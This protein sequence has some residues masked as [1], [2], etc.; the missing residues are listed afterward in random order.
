MKKRLLTLDDLY[1]FYSTKK[2]SM[3]FSS[4]KSGY[5]LAVQIKGTFEIVNNDNSEG[6]LYGKCRAF[7]DLGNKNK[8]YIDTEILKEKMM[9]LKDRP[10][11]AHISET[12]E[13]DE[14]GN[15]IKDFNGHTM[16]WDD[17]LQKFIYIEH[18]V[19]HF[20]NPEK[21]EL[22]YDETYDRHFV[23]GDIV[24]YEE[25]SDACDI[26]RRRETVD[27]SV[28]LCIRDLTYNCKTGEMHLNDFYVQGCTLLGANYAPGM[29]GSRVTLKDFSESNNSVFSNLEEETNQK[30]IETLEKLNTTITALS[31]FNIDSKLEEGRKETVKFEELLSKYGKTLEDITFEYENLSDEELEIQ[32]AEAF[33]EENTDT[34]D[35][36]ETT[37]ENSASEGDEE[38]GSEEEDNAVVNNNEE[39]D[40]ETDENINEQF[41]QKLVRTYEISHDDIRYG[42]YNLLSMQEEADNEW[43]FINA[44]YD[45][46]FTYENWSGDKIYGQ[47]Y[48]KDNDNVSF[49]GER[50]NLH[51]ELL[52]D[53]EYAELV[54]MRSNYSSISEELSKYQKA[55]L[56]KKKEVIFADEAYANYLND[57]RF[58]TLKNNMDNYSLEELE[59][60][61]SL[62]FAECVKKSGTFSLHTKTENKPN[63]VAFAA[64]TNTEETGNAFLN[65]LRDIARNKNKKN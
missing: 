2:K 49:D 38:A 9:S 33:G 57:E 22:V 41:S 32:F 12:G 19:G 51:R 8:S 24:V 55:E 62:A 14:N 44:V 53:S 27:C 58:V 39:T 37:E 60:E 36:T 28:E 4:D 52:T 25:Y 54:S 42:L 43:Y 34:T 10:V 35:N 15:P 18:P 6:L 21:F 40:V 30:L 13:F 59:K 26:L 64:T 17:D 1:D 50:W 16:E 11:M 23:S 7:H 31:N 29:Q 65:G 48:S 20:I 56:N 45:N 3:T 47:S 46:H 61:C 63:F 5:N